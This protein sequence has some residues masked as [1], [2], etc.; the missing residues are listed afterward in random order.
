MSKYIQPNESGLFDAAIR[1]EELQEMG[2]PLAR[3]D[4]VIDWTLFGPVLARIS[5][6]EP[7][8][9]GGRPPFA[10]LSMFKALVIQSLSQ[11]SDEQLQFQMTDRL[12]FNRFPGFTHADK[13]PDQK[14]LWAFREML[15]SHQ[16]IEPLFAIF[17][18]ALESKGMFARKGQM[19][20]ATFVEVP[21]Q[22]NH[23]ALSRFDKLPFDF[24]QGLSLSNGKAPSLPRGSWPKGSR[25][26]N[27]TIKAGKLPEG[28]EEQPQKARQ[29]DVD[30]RW[31]KKNGERYYGCKNH[32]KVDSRSK[33][34]GKLR[35]ER[36]IENFTVTPASVHES[37]ALD[38]LIAEGD[39][40]TYVDS[41]YTG[42]R[43][44]AIFSAKK[45]AAKPIERTY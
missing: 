24:A 28:W 3:L 15:T 30:A 9:P 4:Q 11:L 13:S 19:V 27:A 14:T 36:L 1:L 6:A 38:E 22:R 2:D 41:A 34:F 35:A 8:G 20:D 40:T 39:P 5:K 23:S 26:E 37:N 10:C 33:P 21:R 17:H 45:V 43:C 16:L 12:S 31:T 32:V 44:E 7:K 25:E 42:A 29:K 18:A